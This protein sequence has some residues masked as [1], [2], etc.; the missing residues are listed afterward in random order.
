MHFH[1]ARIAP[2]ANITSAYWVWINKVFNSLTCNLFKIIDWC[3]I[4]REDLAWR[5]LTVVLL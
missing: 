3:S 2:D 1:E 5:V 4:L